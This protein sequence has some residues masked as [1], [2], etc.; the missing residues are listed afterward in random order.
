M[1]IQ[2]CKSFYLGTLSSSQK[3]VYNVHSKKDISTGIPKSD[4]RGLYKKKNNVTV[5]SK[6]YV[7]NHINRFPCVESHY[8]RASTSK[9]YLE[10]HLNIT[11]MYDLYVELCQETNVTPVKSSMYRRIF[12][13]E[14]NLDFHKPKSD[15]CG[16]CEK[17]QVANKE[18]IFLRENE[19]ISY[20]SHIRAKEKMRERKKE[21]KDSEIPILCFDLQNVITCPKSEVGPTFY[22]SKLNVYNLT[23]HLSTNKMV[24]CAIWTEYMSGRGGNDLASAFTK[25]L[26]KVFDD[27]EFQDIITWSDSCVPQNRNSIISFAIQNFLKTHSNV[28]SITMKFSVPGHSC[29]Q[30]IDNIHSQIEK[31]FRKIEFYSPLGILRA[32]KTINRKKPFQIL[33]MVPEDFKNFADCAKKF[34]YKNIPFSNVTRLKFTQRL[35][36]VEYKKTHDDEE[37]FTSVSLKYGEKKRKFSENT[38]SKLLEVTPQ[39]LAT[40]VGLSDEKKSHLRAMLPYMPLQDR[41][42]Y[43]VILN[44]GKFCKNSFRL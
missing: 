28:N 4:E 44:S 2:V 26:Q 25:I 43:N 23:A 14:F 34:N 37:N 35:L 39:P 33:Q 32:L 18:G 36:E 21:D 19:V 15:R 24:Y 29:I 38:I 17:Y 13:T 1:K 16:I 42:Y 22:H 8:C 31:A 3:P 9:K 20:E 5:E 41:A 30:E 12:C 11:K 6:N 7:K 27:N 40:G 10:S